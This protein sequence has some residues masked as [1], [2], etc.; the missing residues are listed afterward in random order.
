MH[1]NDLITKHNHKQ[2]QLPSNVR[3]HGVL[4]ARADLPDRSNAGRVDVRRRG[5]RRVQAAHRGAADDSPGRVVPRGETLRRGGRQRYRRPHRNEVF[6]HDAQAG[7]QSDRL[8]HNLRAGADT[9]PPGRTRRGEF[10][11]NEKVLGGLD[12][13]VGGFAFTCTD[14]GH[15]FSLPNRSPEAAQARKS[16]RYLRPVVMNNG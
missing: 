10:V 2:F 14:F 4:L 12:W 16:R 9:V 13:F 5:Q 1:K 8:D 15:R 3:P 11:Q 6:Q 7:A